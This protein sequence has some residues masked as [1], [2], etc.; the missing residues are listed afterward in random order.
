MKKLYTFMPSKIVECFLATTHR[1]AFGTK[2]TL[3]S[4]KNLMKTFDKR[5]FGTYEH[6]PTKIVSKILYIEIR[7]M[8][9]G[10]FGIWARLEIFDEKV[11]QL[12]ENGILKG[13]SI[14]AHQNIDYSKIIN[15]RVDDRVFD[16]KNLMLIESMFSA[17]EK[18]RVSLG[19]SYFRSAEIVPNILCILPIEQLIYLGIVTAGLYFSKSFGTKI[20]NDLGSEVGKDVS[21]I[22]R[23]LADKVEFFL[24]EKGYKEFY[25]TLILR[26]NNFEIVIPY[27]STIPKNLS[28]KLSRLDE[29]LKQAEFPINKDSITEIRLD[30]MGEDFS[31]AL[32]K[33]KDHCFVLNNGKWSK[34][35]LS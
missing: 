16:E 9:D 6:D 19:F 28:E 17:D 35:V 31:L 11:I 32:I 1:D 22:Y 33:S 29:F 12:T 8:K 7:E 2:L 14:A 23:K 3:D 18:E 20:G 5:S 15:V 34:L 27:K 13:F 10:E 4:L 24:S 21:K 25:F 26:D 30:V